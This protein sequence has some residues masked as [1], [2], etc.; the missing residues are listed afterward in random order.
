MVVGISYL[1]YIFNFNLF[2]INKHT[3][4]I[5]GIVQINFY[6]QQDYI[7]LSPNIIVYEANNKNQPNNTESQ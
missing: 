3:M 1:N 5:Q 4:E 7:S 6:C 2:A